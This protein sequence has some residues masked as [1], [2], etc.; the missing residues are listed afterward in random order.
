MKVDTGAAVS[1]ISQETWQSQP[2]KIP[3]KETD[4]RLRTYTGESINVLGEAM[5]TVVYGE[6]E[7]KL[8]LLVV[9]ESDPSLLGRNWL[10]LIRLNWP[11]IKKVSLE[12]DILLNKYG[13]LFKDELG[14]VQNYQV[15]LHVNSEAL[16]RFCEARPVPYALKE[17]IEQ[18]LERLEH[19]KIIEKVN[20]SEWASPVVPVLKP[21]GHIRL[22]GDYKI[23][24]ISITNPREFVCH[25]CWGAKVFIT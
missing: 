10:K 16:P 6:Q 23:R 12:L 1:L 15:K 22:C 19:L 11:E 3:L 13:N 17:P 2:H 7:A 18:E 4:V 25:T 24:Q 5:V 21:D 20:H 8:A 9:P 14:T